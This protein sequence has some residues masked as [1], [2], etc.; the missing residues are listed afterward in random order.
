LQEYKFVVTA[1]DGAPDP[2]IATATVT[3][4]IVDVDD[5][6]PIFHLTSYEAQVPENV[7]DYMVTQ[8]KVGILKVIWLDMK[9]FFFLFLDCVLTMV[10]T[11]QLT[12][13]MELRSLDARPIDSFPA[14]YGTRRFN[15]EFTRALHLFLS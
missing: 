9:A 7:P 4:E 5:E 1:K 2:R 10:I 15:T 13:S 11:N 12:N 6:V 14:F 3:V 8:V